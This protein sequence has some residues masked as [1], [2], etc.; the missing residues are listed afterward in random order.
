M[1]IYHMLTLL[2]TENNSYILFS[3][4]TNKLNFSELTKHDKILD[5]IMRRDAEGA[6][7]AMQSHI[8]KLL[9]CVESYGG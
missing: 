2:L 8:D 3:N 7:Q 6:Y 4:M 5:A 9:Q 1:A